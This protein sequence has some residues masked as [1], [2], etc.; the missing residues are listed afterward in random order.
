MM[1]MYHIKITNAGTQVSGTTK[2][3]PKQAMMKEIRDEP[4]A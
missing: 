3:D 1:G 4:S 2:S